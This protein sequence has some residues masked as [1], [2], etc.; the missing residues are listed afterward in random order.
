MLQE[1]SPLVVGKLFLFLL[2]AVGQQ[3]RWSITPII[4]VSFPEA[5]MGE[6]TLEAFRVVEEGHLM[7]VYLPIPLKLASWSPGAAVEGAT[8]SLK[9]VMAE[10]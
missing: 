4:P 9:V 7:F 3:D 8:A 6:E 5:L 2:E 10:A 1:L